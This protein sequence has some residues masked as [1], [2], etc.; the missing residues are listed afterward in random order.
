MPEEDGKEQPLK[1]QQIVEKK[2][3]ERNEMQ[4][5]LA[6]LG[7]DKDSIPKLSAEQIDKVLDERK[8]INEYVREDHKDDHQKYVIAKKNELHFLYVIGVIGVLLAIFILL[9]K[10]EYFNQFL[11]FIITAPGAYGYGKYKGREQLL[12]KDGKD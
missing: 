12:M 1:P 4:M 6:K 11:T 2:S 7:D 5:L 9:L 8:K 3:I 10:P